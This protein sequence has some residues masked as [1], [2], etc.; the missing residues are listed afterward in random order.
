VTTHLGLDIGGTKTEAVVTDAAGLV[1]G[2]HRVDSG[3]GS[4]AVV[5]AALEASDAACALAGIE[6]RALASAGVGIPGAISDGIVRHAVNLGVER[7]DLAE[8]LGE[9]WGRRPVI[10]NDV[11]AAAVG[12]WVLAG[13]G[14]RSVAYLNLGTGLAAGIIVGGKLWRGARGAAGEIGHVSVDPTGPT[15][16]DGLPGG[17]EA[18]AGGVG[19]ALTSG[20]GRTAAEILADPNADAARRALFF[21]VASA[22]RVLVLTIDVEEVIIGGGITHMGD[23]LREGIRAQLDEWSTAS[24]FLRSVDLGKRFRLLETDEPVA[25][26]GAAMVGAGRG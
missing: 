5:S 22:I 1:L 4:D 25:A 2:H 7:L 26:I 24:G 9:A 13:D 14:D 17:L 12:A 16:P 3:H 21:G 20:D 19:I 23:A 8:A 10:E 11:N 18:Y 15:G 6:P